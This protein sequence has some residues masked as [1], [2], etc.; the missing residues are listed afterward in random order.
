MN[1][2]SSLAAGLASRYDIEREIGRGG[3][4]T[5]Y[6][7]R[8][9]RHDRH[10]ALKVLDPEL[11]AVLG[12]ERFLSEIR[13]TANLQHPNLLPLFDSG[14]VGG[15]LFY[16]MPFV[17]GENL[18]HRMDRERQLPIDEA[19][20]IAVC[21]ASALDYA[22]RHGVIHRDLK[23]ENIL[24]HDGQPLVADF[25]IALAVSNAGGA[26]VT[27]TGLSLG[28]PQYM[29]PEQATGDRGI[30][31]RTDIYSLGAVTYE[32][33]AGEP[34]HVGTT[35]QAIIARLM[36]EEPR[37]LT[38]ARR[39]VPAHVDAA[40]RCALEKLPADRF[41]T[42]AQFAEA[43]QGRGAALPTASHTT[44]VAT[45]R[46]ARAR[47]VP[48][49]VAGTLGLLAIVAGSGWW[50][51]A[52]A[53]PPPRPIITQ[54]LPPAGHEFASG[55]QFAVSNDGRRIAFV[56]RANDGSTSMWLQSLD[57]VEAA[58]LKG[59]EGASRPFWSP[60]DASIGFF[61][62][63][64]LRT[65][66]AVGGSIRTLCRAPNPSGGV[67]SD[68]GAIYFQSAPRTPV[69]RVPAS[70]GE[71]AAI[72]T[73]FA[74]RPFRVPGQRRLVMGGM[75]ARILDLESRRFTPIQVMTG[76]P[77]DR[78]FAPPN[79]L[80]YTEQALFAAPFDLTTGAPVGEPR[81]VLPEIASPGGRTEISVS[82][83]GVL[84]ARL[85]A[86]SGSRLAVVNRRGEI[87]DSSIVAPRHWNAAVS[88]DGRRIATSGWG[89]TV[90]DPERGTET[91]MTEDLSGSRPAVNVPI[92]SARDSVILFAPASGGI[93][94]WRLTDGT[95]VRLIETRLRI[96]LNDLSADG[97]L[98]LG[99]RAA[100]DS[101]GY[102]DIVAFDLVTKELRQLIS[103][104]AN[105]SGARL[106]PDGR[107]IAYVSDERG[108]R[109]LY[110]RPFHGPGAPIPISIAG[111]F[112][113]HWR[114]DGAELFFLS[115]QGVIM[116]IATAALPRVGRATAVFGSQGLQIA[117][118]RMDV[119]PDGQRFLVRIPPPPSSR[120]LT[121]VQNWTGLLSR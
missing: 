40:V 38:A 35:A 117:D 9:V 120:A 53:P 18:R 55:A 65:M 47:V 36:T 108:R 58:E 69:R 28:T 52:Q 57:T 46:S 24:L 59:T 3:M 78:I 106:S 86:G 77:G 12:A 1:V 61:A 21:I 88:R 89:L 74:S 64:S 115:P 15:L 80:L 119:W 103:A 91:V 20:R 4:A 113:P 29:S 92:W 109:E 13:V 50:R 73:V 79:Y 45:P 14:N 54:L 51:A 114:G 118:E 71:C 68:D 82:P 26:R 121:I 43:L 107:W 81:R 56:A 93:W 110:L 7:A 116:S 63:G 41:A 96:T 94:A 2:L 48:W 102:S 11:G 97:R 22:H 111:G 99:T 37:S 10:V 39:S 66:S 72:D 75:P 105:L 44:A 60:D 95:R 31:A 16:V 27:Q 34:P 70:G 23:P 104:T 67:W 87:L 6:L 33:L 49:A 90:H 76:S 42:A 17:E 19:V 112:S 100:S 101:V 30:D 62:R 8:D 83:A 84:A 85:A 25:G 98:L 5:V 32:M